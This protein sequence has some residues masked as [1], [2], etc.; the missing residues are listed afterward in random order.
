MVGKVIY[1]A[2]GES[3]KIDCARVKQ[4]FIYFFTFIYYYFP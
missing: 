1:H 4:R 3:T 2:E